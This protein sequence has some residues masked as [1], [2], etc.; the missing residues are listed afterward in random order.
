VYPGEF[1]KSK[2]LVLAW[3]A[4]I[5]ESGDFLFQELCGTVSLEK[6]IDLIVLPVPVGFQGSQVDVEERIGLEREKEIELEIRLV[7]DMNDPGNGE[8]RS[9]AEVEYFSERI[10]SP[11][12][13][14]CHRVADHD[15]MRIGKGFSRTPFKERKGK[16]VEKGRVDSQKVC[17]CI[18]LFLVS[19]NHVVGT[20]PGDGCDFG[21]LVLES[22]SKREGEPGMYRNVIV[23]AIF[24]DHSVNVFGI[25]VKPVIGELMPDPK[26]NQDGT[27]YPDGQSSDA[28]HR[29]PPL[30]AHLPERHLNGVQEEGRGYAAGPMWR[31]QDKTA[32]IGFLIF[33][34][35]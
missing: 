7:R 28:D 29:I 13:F 31:L 18:G 27:S 35:N 4:G 10:F 32:G 19:D 16:Y 21:E 3:G 12:I 25:L 2:D 17:F 15:G 26:K 1:L 5:Q 20:V 11:E 33:N 6:K 23:Q 30:A 34:S 8:V 14:L 9:A 22:R 24:H